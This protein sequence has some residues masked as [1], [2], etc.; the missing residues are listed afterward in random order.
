MEC[1]ALSREANSSLEEWLISNGINMGRWTLHFGVHCLADSIDCK[2]FVMNIHTE[3]PESKI[4]TF[5]IRER[6]ST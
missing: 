5:T 4:H 1:I 3:N 6:K 2:Q